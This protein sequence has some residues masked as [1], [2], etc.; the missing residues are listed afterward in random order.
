MCSGHEGVGLG[1][2]ENCLITTAAGKEVQHISK[3]KLKKKVE[4]NYSLKKEHCSPCALRWETS[5]CTDGTR[6]TTDPQITP[7][8]KSQLHV[9]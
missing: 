8:T 7:E 4:R 6:P 9:L 3:R 5:Y 2:Q 1:K